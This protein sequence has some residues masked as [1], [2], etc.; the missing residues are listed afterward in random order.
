MNL[1]AALKIAVM[2]PILHDP[3]ATR[4]PQVSQTPPVTCRVWLKR[5]LEELDEEG[6]IELLGSVDRIEEQA[7]DLAFKNKLL[8]RRSV[9]KCDFSVA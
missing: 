5:A 7:A 2:D 9:G 6:Y 8:R 3:L 1:L 4:L